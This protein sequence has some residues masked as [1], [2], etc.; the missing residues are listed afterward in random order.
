D[1]PADHHANEAEQA[2]RNRG[3]VLGAVLHELEGKHGVSARKGSKT[4]EK[5]RYPG[6]KRQPAERSRTPGEPVHERREARKSPLR[7]NDPRPRSLL[8]PSRELGS[9]LVDARRILGALP[10]AYAL[11]APAG[12]SDRRGRCRS[13]SLGWGR[14]AATWPS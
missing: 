9:C 5:S 10:S 8:R 3:H 1:V 6:R 12:A 2:T 14:W 4:L 13:R 11:A 7:E